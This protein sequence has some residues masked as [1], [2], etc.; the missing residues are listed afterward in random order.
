[1]QAQHRHHFGEQN[2]A[3][4]TGT[5]TG[6]DEDSK[7]VKFES[8]SDGDGGDGDGGGGAR[9]RAL[10]SSLL[11]LEPSRRMRVAEACEHAFL[12]H[13]EEGGEGEGEA[14]LYPHSLHASTEPVVKLPLLRG[15]HQG[16]GDT[17]GGGQEDDQ[18]GEDEEGALW[19]RRQFSVLWAPM[20]AH[21]EADTSS[22]RAGAGG[23]QSGAAWRGVSPYRLTFAPEGDVERRSP[24]FALH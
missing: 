7:A 22:G 18:Q 21:Y 9:Q 15:Q 13:G 1:M 10:V 23:G 2:Y 19:A 5:R 14:P 24:F 4:A 3:V 12:I 17:S 8:E 20:P 11:C 6:D 16:S